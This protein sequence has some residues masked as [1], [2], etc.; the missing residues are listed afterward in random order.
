MHTSAE[1]D[2]CATTQALG[3]CSTGFVGL[4]EVKSEQGARFTVKGMKNLL[5]DT[6][7]KQHSTNAYCPSGK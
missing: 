3:K 6:H 7:T 2:D 1:A 5:E 4:E